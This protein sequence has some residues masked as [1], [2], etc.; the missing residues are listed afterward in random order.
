MSYKNTVKDYSQMIGWLTRDK[1]T[2]VPGSMAHGLRTGF[3]DGGRAGFY[4]GMSVNKAPQNI[5]LETPKILEPTGYKKDGTPKYDTKSI[6]ELDPN[7][8][9]KF[10]KGKELDKVKKVFK[11]GTPGSIIDDAVEIRNVIVLNKGNISSVEDLGNLVDFKSGNKVDTKRVKAALAIAKDN[12]SEIGNFKF[13]PNRYKGIRSKEVRG[14]DMVVDAI[15]ASQ[16]SIVA[17]KPDEKL[18]HFLPDNMGFFYKAP[19]EATDI[20]RLLEKDEKPVKGNITGKRKVYSANVYSEM[21]NLNKDQIKYI[22]DRITEETGKPFTSK[23]YS[24]LVDEVKDFRSGVGQAA[25]I[26]K[27]NEKTYGE[28]V[29]LANDNIIQNL[30]KG[31]LNRNTQTELLDRATKLV[32]G[33][34]STASRRLFQMAEA[35]SDT[36]DQYKNLGVE[37][38][39][40]KASKI[41][42]TGR[43]LGGTSN[44]YAMSG[45]VY[46]YYGNVVDKALEA[47]EGESFIGKYQTQIKNLLDKGQSPD[48][49]FSLTASAR[50]GLSPY[51]IFTQNL[52]TQVNSAIKGAYIDGALSRTHKKLQNIFKGKKYNQLNAKDKKAV[53]DLVETFEKTKVNALNQPTNPGEIRADFNKQYGKDSIQYENYK[54]NGIVPKNYKGVKPIYLTAAEKKNIQLPEF[55]LKNAPSKSISDYK[56]FDKNLQSAFDK[57]YDAVGYS[58]KVPKEYLTQKQMIT[59]LTKGASMFGAKGNIAAGIVAGVLGYKGED[60]LKGTGLMDKEYELTASAG[61]AP[62][63]EKGLSTGEK[64]AIGTGA[65]GT[66]GTKIGRKALGKLTG[67]GLGPTG[68]FALTKAFEPEGG[69]DLSRT[70]DRIG[71]EAE[72]ALAPTLVQGVTDVSSKIKNPLLRKGIETLA[73]VRIPGVM[74]PAN[75]LRIARIASPIGIASLAGEGLYHLGKKGYEQRK[76]MENMTEE[77]KRDFLADQYENLGGVFGEGA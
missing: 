10:P 7:Y 12:F 33:D 24:N 13:I 70:A 69:Y 68:M 19:G 30:L 2:D 17:G 62:I 18:I 22:T 55:D 65:A 8:L 53:N 16:N 72:A 36:T 29:D 49:I 21:Y 25:R 61:D 38:N 5:K 15:K 67:L 76:L 23:D 54:K 73:G 59:N 46:D 51:A 42:A 37:L 40:N 3:Y 50:R 57:S 63:V 35:M 32:D 58:M 44:R 14:L 45:V 43:N 26:A 31:D 41:I 4:K 39:N 47:T 66:L 1:T 52:K 77:E 11:S 34:I 71:F 64:A 9:G 27:I 48:E 6:R 20:G 74:N 75:A 60:I 56:N 28:I